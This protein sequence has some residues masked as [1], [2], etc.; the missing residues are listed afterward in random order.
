ME[1]KETAKEETPRKDE[2][3]EAEY[4]L[5]DVRE[6]LAQLQKSGKQAQVKELISSLGVKKL[7]EIPEEKYGELMQKAGEL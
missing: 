5:V 1:R 7:T 6:K 4:T 3:G 2:N